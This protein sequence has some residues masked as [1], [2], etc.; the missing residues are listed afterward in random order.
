MEGTNKWNNIAEYTGSSLKTFRRSEGTTPEGLIEMVDHLAFLVW[1]KVP[2]DLTEA[3][4]DKRRLKASTLL[5]W[6][7][8]KIVFVLTDLSLLSVWWGVV[9]TIPEMRR[10]GGKIVFR[11]SRGFNSMVRRVTTTKVLTFP[12]PPL[13]SVGGEDEESM[14]L[15]TLTV[16]PMRSK[17]RVSVV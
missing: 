15:A 6:T 12:T 3:V 14:I 2:N 1:V 9:P 5:V 4:A 16:P 10:R 13:Q 11:G 17:W 8:T 7:L